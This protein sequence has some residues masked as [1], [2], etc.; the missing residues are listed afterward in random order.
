MPIYRL[1]GERARAYFDFSALT[2]S[3]ALSPRSTATKSSSL[4]DYLLRL[5]ISAQHASAYA[6]MLDHRGA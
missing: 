5:G 6:R 1:S 4:A 2:A 3:A